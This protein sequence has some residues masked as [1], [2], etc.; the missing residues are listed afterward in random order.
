ML[1][2]AAHSFESIP[3]EEY[4]TE[5]QW[6]PD[7][8]WLRN[9]LRCSAAV[10]HGITQVRNVSV[11]FHVKHDVVCF[12]EVAGNGIMFSLPEI[13]SLL[14]IL[15]LIAGRDHLENLLISGQNYLWLPFTQISAALACGGSSGAL[16][17][18]N[19]T[20]L[21]DI[22]PAIA[23]EVGVLPGRVPKPRHYSLSLI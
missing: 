13:C 22:A 10:S 11:Q 21:H 18:R 12:G 9:P 17:L 1:L 23:D 19:R 20:S 4:V 6:Q 15:W 5:L 8:F 2:S 16:R 7:K 14:F 3:I